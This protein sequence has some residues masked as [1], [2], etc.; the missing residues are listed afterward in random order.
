MRFKRKIY[1]RKLRHK[2]IRKLLLYGIIMPSTLI[3]LGYLVASL[4]ILPAMAG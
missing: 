1:Y 2:K 4:I 3:L